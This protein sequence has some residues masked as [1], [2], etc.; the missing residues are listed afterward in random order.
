[1]YIEK[2]EKNANNEMIIFSMLFLIMQWIKYKSEKKP[3]PKY[4][5]F[6]IWV[7]VKD[8]STLKSKR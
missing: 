4:P 3:K 8:G 5:I 7:I 2:K 1:M 6:V